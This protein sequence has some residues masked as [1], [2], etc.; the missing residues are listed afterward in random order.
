MKDAEFD[1]LLNQNRLLTRLFLSVAPFIVKKRTLGEE[2][3]LVSTDG[4][5]Y[6]LY[7]HR[8]KIGKPGTR[9][10]EA[11]CTPD[12][13]AEVFCSYCS[14]LCSKIAPTVRRYGAE[15][16]LGHGRPFSARM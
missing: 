2:V 3:P 7:L 13:M 16:T 8:H 4:G 14:D 15:N 1:G 12:E 6:T 5:S 11:V 10:S 9:V